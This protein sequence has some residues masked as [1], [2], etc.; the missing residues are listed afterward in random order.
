MRR[1]LSIVVILVIVSFGGVAFA[2]DTIFVDELG[3][4]LNPPEG[5]TVIT[6]DTFPDDNCFKAIGADGVAFL[7]NLNNSNIYICIVRDDQMAEIMVTMQEDSPSKHIFDFNL[8][9]DEQLEEFAKD[10]MGMEPEDLLKSAGMN[11]EQK[12]TYEDFTLSN[13]RRYEHDQAKFLVLDSY[14]KINDKPLYGRQYT[15]IINGQTIRVLL[16]SYG[17]RLT[18]DEEKVLHDMVGCIQFDEVKKKPEKNGVLSFGKVLSAFKTAL[19]AGGIFF[20][21]CVL[22]LKFSAIRKSNKEK[23]L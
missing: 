6:R 20:I 1:L 14:F 22:F 23:G 10:I 21:T 7:D 17:A 2:D 18:S 19:S 3:L 8:L 12:D 16:N 11:E 13:Y 4:T 9:N 5:W 15:T